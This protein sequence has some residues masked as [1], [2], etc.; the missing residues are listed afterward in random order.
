M[1]CFTWH[2]AL[3]KRMKKILLIILL[4]TAGVVSAQEISPYLIGTNAW[5]PPWKPGSK[6]EYLWDELRDGGVRMIR[7]GGRT[8]QNDPYTKEQIAGLV[9]SIHNI[10]AKAIIQVPYYFSKSQT[11]TLVEY[12]NSTRSLNVDY[13][14]I[15]NEPDWGDY[16]ML[17]SEVAIYIRT[18]SS[19]LKA[20]DPKIKVFAPDLC[21]FNYDDYIKPLFVNAGPADVSGKDDNGNYYV[22]V[23]CWHK[24][25]VDSLDDVE[26]KVDQA[27]SIIETINQTRPEGNK[28]T[29]AITEFNSHWD[30]SQASEDQK[31]W[32]FH[33]GQIFAEVYD[34]AMRKDGLTI[35]P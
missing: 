2:K 20:F 14:S 12:I 28:M 19:A 3:K 33:T 29:W 1:S 23:L 26:G 10:G 18:I 25:G 11:Q 21:W 35:C 22:D 31:V 7:V 15:G 32:S 27:L 9:V 13:W 34:M 4:L 16:P 17:V 30:N 24:Y 5:L 6:I 8:A